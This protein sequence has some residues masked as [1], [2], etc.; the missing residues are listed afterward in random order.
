MPKVV[1]RKKSAQ[2]SAEPYYAQE[3]ECSHPGCCKTSYYCEEGKPWCGWHG[4]MCSDRIKLKKNPQKAVNEAEAIRKHDASVEE[5]CAANQADAKKGKLICTQIPNMYGRVTHVDGYLT[6]APN[7]KHNNLKGC[8]PGC[9]ELSPKR[10]G[11]VD[12]VEGLPPAMTI[13]GFHQGRKCWTCELDKE[14]KLPG[15]RFYE[16]RDYVF[17]IRND[18]PRHKYG[19]TKEIHLRKLKE[20]G[21]VLP[22][23]KN[24]KKHNANIPLYSVIPMRVDGVLVEVKMSYVDSRKDYC[25]A[26]ARLMPRTKAFQELVRRLEAGYNINICGYDGQTFVDA[27]DLRRLYR[28]KSRPFGHELV[29]A[30]LLLGIA[31]W[32]EEEQKFEVLRALE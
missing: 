5:A 6:V 14:T 1:G 31:P 30:C 8:L 20:L 16:Q 28:D 17:G 19:H 27:G 21:E 10:L 32:D 22:K 15:K 26:C 12:W 7:N 4:P 9:A 18:P 13:E 29:L 23:A 24:G 2:A 3:H 25:V 11:P